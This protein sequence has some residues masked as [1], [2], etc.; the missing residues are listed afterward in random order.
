MNTCVCMC[1]QSM[2]LCVHVCTEGLATQIHAAILRV[3][4]CCSVLQCVAVCCSVLQCVAVLAMCA[5]VESK[6]I[7]THMQTRRMALAACS[8]AEYDLCAVL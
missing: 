5:C 8:V 1:A 4:M 6:F 3:C 2:Y 7:H